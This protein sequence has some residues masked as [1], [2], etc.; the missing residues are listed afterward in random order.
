VPRDRRG[1]LRRR[2]PFWRPRLRARAREGG[3]KVTADRFVRG[4]RY[5]VIGGA[6]GW[7]VV[8]LLACGAHLDLGALVLGIALG[9]LPF[10]ALALI[11][12]RVRIRLALVLATAAVLSID[13]VAALP[14]MLGRS[15]TASVGLMISPLVGLAAVGALF[16]ISATAAKLSPLRPQ[17]MFRGSRSR[18]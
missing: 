11:A 3:P 8:V 13:M 17:I 4:Y 6:V 10:A 7:R 16:A 15:S 1:L 5:V 9:V 12:S 14:A 18:H 2:P